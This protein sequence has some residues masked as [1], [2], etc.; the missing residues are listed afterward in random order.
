MK[1]DKLLYGKSVIERIV[2]IEPK[3]SSA[4]LFIQEVDGSIRS[5][6]VKNKYWILAGRKIDDRWI[7]LKGELHF[8]YGR[9]FESREDYSK[10]RQ[11]LRNSDIYSIFD[12]K[13][14]LMCKDGISYFKGLSVEDVSVLSFDIETTSLDPKD[15]NAMVLLISNTYRDKNKIVRKLFA[16]DEYETQG[17][18]LEAWCAWVRDINPSIMLGHNIFGF[19]LQYLKGIAIKE[20]VFLHLGRDGSYAI[21]D[22]FES[23]FRKEASQFITYHR[24]K[25][26][27][28]E[29]IDTMFLAYKH[30]IASRKYSSY[31]LKNIIKQE[32]LE[33][34]GR[35]FYDASQIRFNYKDPVEWEKIKEYCKDDSDD[36]LMLYDLMIKPFFYMTQSIPKSFQ[37]MLESASGA[38]LNSLMV[39]S[40]LQEGHSIPKA[41]ESEHFEGGISLGVSGIYKNVF[42]IDVSSLYPSIILQYE[43]YDNIKDPNRN[44]LTAVKEFTRMRLQYKQL[45]KETGKE[46]YDALQGAFKILINSAYGFMGAPGLNFN[47]P[48]MAALITKK[49]REI[50]KTSI[51]W[52][53]GKEYELS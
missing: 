18:M 7:K 17:Q 43:V 39:R 32:G 11:A 29:M 45:L 25:I 15:K 34:Q 27:G 12:P 13:E 49:G 5:E 35:T 30:D 42:K 53:T 8:K 40:Y 1:Y 48:K 44:F 14:A 21:F 3:D 16:Y 4:E 24:C 26:Y 28:R 41:D 2:S 50:L 52:A 6:F 51:K 47:S 33:K 23:R 31:G 37:N 36:S 22:K 46:E 9:Q 19:D 10:A 20:G 38:Q